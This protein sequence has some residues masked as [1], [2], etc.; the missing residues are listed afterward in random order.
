[1]EAKLQQVWQHNIMHHNDTQHNGLNNNT[2]HNHLVSFLLSA[3]ML[4]DAF[5]NCYVKI[6]LN[7]RCKT[8]KTWLSPH[9]ATIYCPDTIMNYNLKIKIRI[10]AIYL[11]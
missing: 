7:C 1:V 5:C 9:M 10:F 11:H 2:Q 8:V 3:F 6:A 4:S